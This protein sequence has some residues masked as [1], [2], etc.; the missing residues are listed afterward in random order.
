MDFLDVQFD[1]ENDKFYPY[2]KPND[3]PLFIH[4]H[5][6]HP[7]NVIKQMPVMTSKRLSNLSCNEE[8]FK[9][10]AISYQP[11]LE[12]SGFT[13]KIEFQQHPPTEEKTPEK[14]HMVQPTL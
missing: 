3:T 4:K 1:L 5:S 13:E 14:D 11:A 12:N 10:A 2:R 8:E 9:K 6:N 7:I